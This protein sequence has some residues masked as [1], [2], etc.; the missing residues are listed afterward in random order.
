MSKI[1][2]K[3]LFGNNTS[4][5]KAAKNL[6]TRVLNLE[7]APVEVT[8]K[9]TTIVVSRKRKPNPAFVPTTYTPGGSALIQTLHAY[10]REY[11]NE[12]DNAQNPPNHVDA[13]Q[14]LISISSS[15]MQ[16]LGPSKFE[17]HLPMQIIS[18][19]HGIFASTLGTSNTRLWRST[20]G[21]L[22]FSI[23]WENEDSNDSVF[24]AVDASDRLWVLAWLWTPGPDVNTPTLLKSE[25]GDGTDLVEIYQWNSDYFSN[26]SMFRAIVCHP[27]NPD[28]L[29]VCLNGDV[30]DS[31][32]PITVFTT[33]NS[34]VSFTEHQPDVGDSNTQ[35]E[36][37]FTLSGTL[38]VTYQFYD[39][40]YI[41][42]HLRAARAVY[43]Y[44]TLTP[45][46]VIDSNS[47]S[48]SLPRILQT[49]NG[50]IYIITPGLRQ[51]SSYKSLD[52]Y[53]Y[54]VDGVDGE[55]F[56]SNDQYSQVLK[57]IAL[58]VSSND[59]LTYQEIATPWLV[60]ESATTENTGLP[61]P[62]IEIDKYIP[63]NISGLLYDSQQLLVFFQPSGNQAPYGSASYRWR[64]NV[65][66][67]HN[68]P[69]G[70][71]TF[72]LG[73]TSYTWR[74]TG[75]AGVWIGS[76]PSANP[77]TGYS[78]IAVASNSDY[79]W[80]SVTSTLQSHL[81]ELL[82]VG[83]LSIDHGNFDLD[84]TNSIPTQRYNGRGIGRVRFW[85]QDATATITD[86]QQL[87]EAFF[88]PERLNITSE[89]GG[90]IRLGQIWSYKNDAWLDIESLF[91]D[92]TNLAN[93]VAR[94]GSVEI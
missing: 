34:A 7:R 20:D 11:G 45:T 3:W 59:G 80:Y 60:P 82:S 35:G 26:V 38:I 41:T 90:E 47:N 78:A 22:T 56:G 48:H 30:F 49:D 94:G 19:A 6:D 83:P 54:G 92:V 58:F 57:Y 64:T 65:V 69:N 52:N 8:N 67:G 66:A 81:T 71:Y 13:D 44:T 93:P 46:A 68:G 29:A 17:G 43:P 16:L 31:L 62:G 25:S 79:I 91:I 88:T 27:T 55:G 4:Q 36:I 33:I 1:R 24:L 37:L 39:I 74:V 18:S 10:F 63:G 5:N 70:D 89:I 72:S 53:P 42:S 28:V 9:T 15:N 84:N 40:D 85:N 12:I 32:W 14:A 75:G 2:T 77:P 50:L 76:S 87:D 86:L 73:G 21:G 23:V 51:V 61:N